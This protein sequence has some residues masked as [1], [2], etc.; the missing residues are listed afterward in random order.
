MKEMEREKAR[1]SEKLKE[2]K[3]N[4]IEASAA[5]SK[6]E[7]KKILRQR[8]NQKSQRMLSRKQRW[9][10]IKRVEFE[11]R[12]T[13]WEKYKETGWERKTEK[14]RERGREDFHMTYSAKS[15]PV[16]ELFNWLHCPKKDEKNEKR[17][18]GIP[19]RGPEQERNKYQ[20]ILL[21]NRAE[22]EP[23]ETCRATSYVVK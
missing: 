19:R 13:R 12:G 17:K 1:V 18:K 8:D 21:K 23:S 6:I 11:E 16:E 20:E 10:G 22:N 4:S 5:K 7:N 9:I 2:T 15:Y 14:E 3:A